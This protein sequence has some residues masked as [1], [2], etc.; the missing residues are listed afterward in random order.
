M[1]DAVPNDSTVLNIPG[2][3]TKLAGGGGREEVV[4]LRDCIGR[5]RL[6]NAVCLGYLLSVVFEA[7]YWC[8]HALE[9]CSP[10]YTRGEDAY[11]TTTC[12]CIGGLDPNR[13]GVSARSEVSIC[14]RGRRAQRY[15]YQR[16]IRGRESQQTQV[17]G[18]QGRCRSRIV[19]DRH[20]VCMVEATCF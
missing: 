7:R 5:E 14:L 1:P 10:S 11:D 6:A 3:T 16:N 18:A 13:S 17:D 19:L 20:Q 12:L 4:Y 9:I 15:V 2:K 8:P